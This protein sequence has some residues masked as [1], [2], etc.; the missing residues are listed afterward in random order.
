MTTYGAYDAGLPCK[1]A[2][3]NSHG[4]PHPNCK[5]YPN[6]AKGGEVSSF[7]SENRMHEKGCEYFADGGEVEA[8]QHVSPSHSVASYI[9]HSG[10]HGLID[11][12]G[13]TSEK[14]IDKYNQAV[15]R[16]HKTFNSKVNHLFKDGPEEKQDYSKAKKSIH[17]WIEK[18]GVHND[19]ME[20]VYKQNSPQ[21]FAAGGHVE[22]KKDHLHDQ[23]IASKYPEHNLLL[24]AAKGRM[25]DYLN[26]LKPQKNVPKLAFDDAPDTRHQEKSYQR[27]LSL[28]AHP[29]H[30]VDKIKDGTVEPEH[31]SHFR[32][33]HPEVDDVL[34]KKMTQKII[35]MQLKGEKPKSHVRQGLS[36]FL[37]TPLSG[38]ITPQNI[39]AAQATFQSKKPQ[40]QDQA[41]TKN[42]KNTSTL[43]KADK[44]YLTGE[45][46]RVA[47]SQK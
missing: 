27:A 12:P 39:Q 15:T 24:Q 13:K 32:N 25:S 20:E 26:S 21:G 17:E 4:K 16:G 18:G 8:P 34:Q 40:Q 7:C 28:A 5:C 11:M 3:C 46:A 1:N 35:E 6:M 44:P 33:L 2:S 45:Q 23:N 37:G 30:I 38:E 43:T 10:L 9:A 41:P 36:L 14:S 47:R 19:I 29:L 31:V 22:A 42:K